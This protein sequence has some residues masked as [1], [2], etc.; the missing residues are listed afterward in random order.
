MDLPSITNAPRE[1]SLGGATYRAKALSLCG[2][3][4]VLAWLEDR[5]GYETDPERP[6]ASPGFTSD[7]ARL[8]LASDEGLAVVLHLSLLPCHPKLSRDDARALVAGMAP[9]QEARLLSIAFRRRPGYSPPDEG[10]GKD[11]SEIAWGETWEAV[12]K[13]N[14]S[15]YPALGNLTL[16]QFDNLAQGGTDQNSLSVFDVHAMWLKATREDAATNQEAGSNDIPATI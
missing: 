16:D 2:L 13:K 4:E 3:G 5:L 12:A 6:G 7:G 11:P 9:D 14:P 15:L 1:I 8:A 10:Q